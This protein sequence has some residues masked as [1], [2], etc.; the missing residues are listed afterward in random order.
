MDIDDLFNNYNNFILTVKCVFKG[1]LYFN[2]K[3]N[4][5]ELERTCKCRYC[6][7]I[8]ATG[9]KFPMQCVYN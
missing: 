4:Y 5:G 9:S 3:E 2:L 7:K 1:N 8:H 6:E